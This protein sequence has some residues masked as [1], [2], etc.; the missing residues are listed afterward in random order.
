MALSNQNGALLIKRFSRTPRIIDTPLT[1][2]GITHPHQLPNFFEPRTNRDKAQARALLHTLCRELLVYEEFVATVTPSTY[3]PS[4]LKNAPALRRLHDISLSAHAWRPLV[5]ALAST[6][7]D[8][9]L[10]S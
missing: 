5:E 2:G 4:V 10:A 6:N 8:C 3:R 9:R 1:P 7:I